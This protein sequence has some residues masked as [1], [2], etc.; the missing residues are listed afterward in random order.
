MLWWIE[1]WASRNRCWLCL[2]A[3]PNLALTQASQADWGGPLHPGQGP[4][5]FNHCWILSPT[6][7]ISVI[8]VSLQKLKQVTF[9]QPPHVAMLYPKSLHKFLLIWKFLTTSSQPCLKWSLARVRGPIAEDSNYFHD[10][11]NPVFIRLTFPGK[12][13]LYQAHNSRKSKRKRRKTSY[14]KLNIYESSYR[15]RKQNDDHSTVSGK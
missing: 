3:T 8:Q 5:F 6:C 9:A 7:S 12:R 1:M 14:L 2:T 10:S 11:S 15:V 13:S 4:N